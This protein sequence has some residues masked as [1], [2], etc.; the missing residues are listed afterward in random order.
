VHR[1]EI[2]KN[3]SRCAYQVRGR[4]GFRPP[5]P[6][7]MVEVETEEELDREDKAMLGVQHLSSE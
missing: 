6:G 3:S 7:C 5:S 1:E 4:C 2:P